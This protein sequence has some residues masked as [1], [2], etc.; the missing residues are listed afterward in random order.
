MI[1][2]RPLLNFFS[3]FPFTYGTNLPHFTHCATGFYYNAEHYR[4]YA[5]CVASATPDLQLPSHLPI[6]WYLITPLG[7]TGTCVLTT[8]PGLNSTDDRLGFEP[9]AY[10]SQFQHPNHLAELKSNNTDTA[11]TLQVN[12]CMSVTG[13]ICCAMYLTYC[14]AHGELGHAAE[15]PCHACVVDLYN[16]RSQRVN[17]CVSWQQSQI[18]RIRSYGIPSCITHWPL[19]IYQISLKSKKLFVDG[20]TE[21]RTYG[22]TFPPLQY[23]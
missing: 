2:P 16:T 14:T 22:R 13:E 15:C 5:W 10:W 21:V 9:H 6:G 11:F 8:S 4:A 1:N 17:C 20:R 18:H 7:D 3:R 19:P 12:V 23:H